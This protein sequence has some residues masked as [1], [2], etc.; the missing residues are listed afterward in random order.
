MS[1]VTSS[2][3]SIV[4]AVCYNWTGPTHQHTPVDQGK[5]LLWGNAKIVQKINWPSHELHANIGANYKLPLCVLVH[6]ASLFFAHVAVKIQFS[7][8]RAGIF[9]F[10]VLLK[11]TSAGKEAM[12]PASSYLLYLLLIILPLICCASFVV[13]R[14]DCGAPVC[15]SRS[16]NTLAL[17]W[18]ER[19]TVQLNGGADVG[20]LLAIN[21]T[22]GHRLPWKLYPHYKGLAK[23]TA[24]K[25]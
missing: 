8:V 10:C 6:H 18:L 17:T 25:I 15:E 12:N 9:C 4:S 1:S 7:E 11:D 19:R 16:I 2:F 21:R 24:E 22:W 5:K 14:A 3:L 13:Q 20:R 23:V